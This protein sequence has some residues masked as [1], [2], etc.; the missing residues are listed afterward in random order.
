MSTPTA[1]SAPILSSKGYTCPMHPE[2]RQA[3]PGACPKCGMALGQIN[4][5]SPRPEDTEYTCPMHPHIVRSEPGSCPICGMALE[6]RNATAE[7][8]AELNDMTRR[9][10]SEE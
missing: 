9:F 4:P 5:V 1:T 7:D 10:R 2:G 6:P 3:T 8:N